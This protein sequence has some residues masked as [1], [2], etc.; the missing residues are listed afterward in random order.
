MREKKRGCLKLKYGKLRACL[1]LRQKVV[2]VIV[3][4]VVLKVGMVMD[5]MA[6]QLL[7]GGN[8]N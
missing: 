3:D 5:T 6:W 4:E 7:V 2:V 1:K 8:V